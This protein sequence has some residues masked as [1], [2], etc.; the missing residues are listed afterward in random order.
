M[1]INRKFGSVSWIKT[2]Y[3]DSYMEFYYPSTL[4]KVDDI[5]KFIED[6]EY[7][8]IFYSKRKKKGDSLFLNETV[9]IND[10]DKLP[11]PK[12]LSIKWLAK[13]VKRYRAE[14]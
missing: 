1:R 3:G 13:N 7:K 5:I 9:L 14:N 4:E 10:N 6:I 8:Y 11:I 2:K 12:N